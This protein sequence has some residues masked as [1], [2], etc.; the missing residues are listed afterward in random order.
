VERLI[1]ELSAPEFAE[2]VAY[3]EI[4]H[5]A[6]GPTSAKKRGMSAAEFRASLAHRVIRKSPT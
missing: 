2:W 3:L 4:Q 6:A 5:E 1:D